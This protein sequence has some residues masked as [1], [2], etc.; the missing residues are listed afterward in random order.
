[1]RARLISQIET[2]ATEAGSNAMPAQLSEAPLPDWYQSYFTAVVESD[3]SRAR[4]NMERAVKD[5]AH[6]LAQL[7]CGSP[8]HPE[9]VQ[10][11][12][13]ALIYLRLLSAST[14]S[15]PRGCHDSQRSWISRTT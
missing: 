14:D 3:E 6:R 12:N 11:L 1:V 10:D 13:C 9:E 2:H 5:I 8:N 7:K 4:I 15:E